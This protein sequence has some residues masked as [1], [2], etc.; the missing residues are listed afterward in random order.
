M[1]RDQEWKMVHLL[2]QY[3]HRSGRSAR[4]VLTEDELRNAGVHCDV[5]TWQILKD[6]SVVKRVGNAFELS[7]AARQLVSTFTLAKGPETDQDIRVDYP[8]AFVVMPFSQPWSNEVYE[9][10][11]KPGIED[12]GFE[13]TRGDSIVRLGDLR[14][15][16]WRS[17]TQAGVIVADVTT[18]NPNVYYEL[19]LA[20][21]LGKATFLFKQEGSSLP[22]DIGGEHFYE[23]NLKHLG[24]NQQ[25][26]TQALRKWA[27]ERDNMFFG[28]KTLADAHHK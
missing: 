13:A 12:A 16:V 15:N 27:N 9:N 24:A 3:A 25:V 23:Y 6:A 1:S 20:D 11:F 2:Y 21:A 19:G 14:T 5:D 8:E 18:P 28:V 17:I 22:A 10:L 7:K 26:L 4:P